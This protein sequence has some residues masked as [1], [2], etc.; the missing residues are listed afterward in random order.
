MINTLFVIVCIICC[1]VI[2]SLGFNFLYSNN[3]TA[4]R[5]VHTFIKTKGIFYAVLAIC[6]F[7]IEF[8]IDGNYSPTLLLTMCIAGFEAVQILITLKAEKYDEEVKKS[9]E[10]YTK[11]A[12]ANLKRIEKVFIYCSEKLEP[13]KKGKVSIDS[14]QLAYEQIYDYLKYYYSANAFFDKFNAYMENK[15]GIVD[16]DHALCEWKEFFEMY[17]TEIVKIPE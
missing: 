14:K 16:V 10:E 15:C 17:G 12:D 1:F 11:A 7:V 4:K 3:K 2:L 13:L 8:C 9:I 5:K 6:S